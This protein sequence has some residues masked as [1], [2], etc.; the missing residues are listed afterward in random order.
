MSARSRRTA[1]TCLCRDRTGRQRM[2][3]RGGQAIMTKGRRPGALAT[4]ATAVASAALALAA[5]SST[6]SAPPASSTTT[7]PSHAVRVPGGTM[8]IAE[9]APGPDYIFPMMSGQYFLDSNF[10]LIDLLFRPLY[11]FGV[12]ST[13]DF[14]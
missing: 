9:A 12:G 6:P 1:T 5:C 11:W 13:P 2:K 14:D 7:A 3:S 4:A 8:T 10:Q